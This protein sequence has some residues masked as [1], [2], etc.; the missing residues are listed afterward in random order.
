MKIDRDKLNF[1]EVTPIKNNNIIEFDWF[2]KLVLGGTLIFL[3]NTYFSKMKMR[4]SRKTN[5]HC[6]YRRVGKITFINYTGQHDFC[7]KNY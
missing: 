7:H 5:C 1:L 3:H 4:K 6:R 2:H